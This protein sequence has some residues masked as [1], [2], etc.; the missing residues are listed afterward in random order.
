ML[1]YLHDVD[2]LSVYVVSIVIAFFFTYCYMLE[3]CDML[4]ADGPLSL[5]NHQ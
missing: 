2:G 1:I 5:I 3:L 4:V